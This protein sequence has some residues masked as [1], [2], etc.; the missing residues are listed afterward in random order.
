MVSHAFV[1]E[2]SAIIAAGLRRRDFGDVCFSV[3]G[4]VRDRGSQGRGAYSGVSQFELVG[5]GAGRGHGDL[6]AADRDADLRSDL[7]ELETDGAAGRGSKPGVSES[8]AP[9]M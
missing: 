2:T 7:Q 8:D 6:D 5:I 9:V 3:V 1:S 4:K